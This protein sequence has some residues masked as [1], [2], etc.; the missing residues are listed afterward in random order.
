[1][2]K[3]SIITAV[4]NGADV[5]ART[6]DSIAAQDY[7]DIEHVVVDGAST[8]GTADIV[9]RMGS[10]NL[11]LV[12]ERDA[13]VYDAFNKGLRLATGDI[14]GYLNAADTYYALDSVSRIAAAFAEPSVDAVFGDVMIVDADATDVAVRR[15]SSARFSP[16]RVANGFMPAHPTLFL[17]RAVYEKF[18]PYD[19]SYRIAGDF[20]L[21]ARVFARGGIRYAYLEEVLVRMPRGGIS[22]SGPRATWTITRE[23]RRACAQNAIPTNYFKLLSRLALKAA[24]F[25]RP[26]A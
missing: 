9:R 19:V 2:L 15:Y 25:V 8:D 21:V 5:I 14:I 13:G 3:V 16:G 22:T 24:E 7:P 18:G 12:S 11:R 1:M 23:M 6:V 4:R 26:R 17:R 10:R 20:E